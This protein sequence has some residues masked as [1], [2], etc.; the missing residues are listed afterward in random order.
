MDDSCWQSGRILSAGF[1]A[2]LVFG[3]DRPGTGPDRPLVR[4]CAVGSLKEE[5]CCNE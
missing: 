1:A 4:D 2:Q 5:P 3:H